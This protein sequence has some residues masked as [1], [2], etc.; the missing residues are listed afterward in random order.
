MPTV[1]YRLLDLK[2]SLNPL[3]YEEKRRG[4]LFLLYKK[5]LR[6]LKTDLFIKLLQNVKVYLAVE[7]RNDSG[8]VIVVDGRFSLA[9]C[10][11]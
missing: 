7:H 5:W 1:A 9:L 4:V 3:C 8:E 10:A 11:R 2:S 6:L